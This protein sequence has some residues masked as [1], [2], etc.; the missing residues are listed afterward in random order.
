LEH[1]VVEATLGKVT[2]GAD[3]IGTLHFAHFV[4]LPNNHLGFFTVYDGNFDRYMQDFTEKI[5][6]IFDVL[7]RFVTDHPPIPVAQNAE[8][9]AKYTAANNY[10]PIGF[11]RAYPGVAVQDIR[12]LLADAKAD[13]AHR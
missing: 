9:F 13:A 1:I 3:A 2:K 8:A 5:G 12:A 11:Y 4:E 6:P 10:P 7:Y